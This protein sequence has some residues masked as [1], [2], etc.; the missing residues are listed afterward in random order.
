M[1][2]YNQPV[3][4]IINAPPVNAKTKLSSDI[5][6]E[7][8]QAGIPVSKMRTSG[9]NL[10]AASKKVIGQSL[11]GK[12]YL[13]TAIRD[14]EENPWDV[15]HRAHKAIRSRV[16]VEPDQLHEFVADNNTDV[17][18]KKVNGGPAHQDELGFDPDWFP[19]ENTIW[20]LDRK[21]SQLDDA[22]KKVES[23][24]F[25]VRIGHLDTGIDK[26]HNV[27]PKRIKEHPL[28]RNFVEGEPKG[29]AQDPFIDGG[30]R[31][32][33]H[34][35]A[36]MAI[37]AGGKVKLKTSTGF[38]EGELGGAPFADVIPCRIASSVVLMKTSAFA[39]ALNYLTSLTL[40]G[41]PV[42]VISMSMG[43]APSKAWADAVN[44]A[45][46]SGITVVTAA[47][48]NFNGLPTKHV[49]F[50]ARFNRVI[51][52]CGVTYELKPYSHNKIGEMQGCYGPD[53]HMDYAIAAFT[54]NTPWAKANTKDKISFAGAGTSSATPQVAAAAAIYYR[55]HQQELA[56]LQPWERVEAIR[57][58]LF[59]SAKKTLNGSGSYKTY[60]GNGIIQ[61]DDAL[62]IPV[63]GNYVKTPPD[64]IPFFPILGTIFKSP[65]QQKSPM[66]EMLNTELA[67][68]TYHYPELEKIVGAD[69]S[70][71]TPKEWQLFTEAVIEH[72]ASSI[73]LKE[74]LVHASTGSRVRI[75]A[76]SRK[77]T[78][79]PTKNKSTRS[80]AKKSKGSKK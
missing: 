11:P 43:G 52:A 62:A 17:P 37:L 67:Q 15:A 45:Y 66:V 44:K 41:N 20:H 32:P 72:P 57:K 10:S 16:F 33:G 4:L 14:S 39:E 58:A 5:K 19:K 74:H 35:L 1:K 46:E 55:F 60:F 64:E 9:A 47:G 22:R 50:P 34:G 54:P 80:T 23:M 21:F 56:A 70:T 26:N 3:E 76:E 24:N 51:A 6:K 53:K 69:Y 75:G 68:L 36:T 42:H 59:T 77:K 13:K 48:N 27:L 49:I 38:F 8:E 78:K 12:T 65:V 79:R 63:N 25:T 18:F 40:S 30:L 7:L 71:A 31:N 28:Q 61:A 2:I 29:D 73:A